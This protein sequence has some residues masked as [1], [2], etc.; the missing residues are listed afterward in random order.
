VSGLHGKED[1]ILLKKIDHLKVGRSALYRHTEVDGGEKIPIT[2]VLPTEFRQLALKCAHEDLGRHCGR[3]IP[4]EV[5]YWPRMPV[6]L[7]TWVSAC[8]DVSTANHLPTIV[9]HWS[10]DLNCV[11]TAVVFLFY[12]M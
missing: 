8:T 7:D 4:R 9:Y 10:L 6:D 5:F 11:K 12:T 1:R 3:H 2:V